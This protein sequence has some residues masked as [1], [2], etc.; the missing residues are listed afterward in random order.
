MRNIWLGMR[1]SLLTLLVTAM[2]IG[3]AMWQLAGAERR[4]L[5]TVNGLVLVPRYDSA[6]FFQDSVLVV[7]LEPNDARRYPI[8]L[9]GYYAGSSVP[10]AERE[11]ARVM[12]EV[13]GEHRGARV[14][15]TRVSRLLPMP[16][17]SVTI[18]YDFWDGGGVRADI[19]VACQSFT[20]GT[21]GARVTTEV[22]SSS[23][24]RV[25]R[26][27]DLKEVVTRD[28]LQASET[29]CPSD[30]PRYVERPDGGDA[31]VDPMKA[32]FMARREIPL[33]VA[34]A[35]RVSRTSG[36]VSTSVGSASSPSVAGDRPLLLAAARRD[37][38]IAE[39][40]AGARAAFYAVT[41]IRVE[42]DTVRLAVGEEVRAEQAL[43]LTALR[44][45]GSIVD[46]FAPLYIVEDLRVAR[47]SAGRFKGLTPGTTV[48]TIRPFMP[49]PTGMPEGGARAQLV[50]KV[51]P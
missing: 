46:R 13:A 7:D 49:G 17:P 45:D 27:G 38:L 25:A 3:L 11:I 41:E 43:R 35:P 4:W 6:R 37:S 50:L 24:G 29:R 31:L 48:V 21:Q 9:S 22:V 16:A 18:A 23:R 15:A 19:I 26:D 33:V 47:M 32:P 39:A 5:V 34:T 10:I 12:R 51:S 36:G 1:Q 44:R 40:M 8:R 42:P 14:T 2:V 20:A 30:Q 28:L